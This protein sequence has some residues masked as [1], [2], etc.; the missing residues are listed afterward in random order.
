MA[1]IERRSGGKS[2]QAIIDA[3]NALLT[4]IDSHTDIDYVAR[5]VL[6]D[7]WV[8]VRFI[9]GSGTDLVQYRKAYDPIP[10]HRFKSL[11]EIMEGL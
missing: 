11:C 4:A 9:D 2:K 1:I 5:I 7:T 6:S 8:G 3:A 10:G